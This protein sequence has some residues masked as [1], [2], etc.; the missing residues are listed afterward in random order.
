MAAKMMAALG[1]KRSSVERSWLAKATRCSTRSSR[2]RTRARRALISSERTSGRKRWPPVRSNVGEH[3]GIARVGLATGGAVAR[4]ARLDHV[5]MDRD[6][7]VPGL[8][9]TLNNQARRPFDGHGQLGRRR[10]LLEFARK[11]AKP[12]ASW[13]ASIRA[14]MRPASST[15]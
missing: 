2:P 7:R 6:H 8:N 13:R 11:S 9:Q 12:A 15:T 1:Q 5:G 10:D 14:R 3:V 4:P